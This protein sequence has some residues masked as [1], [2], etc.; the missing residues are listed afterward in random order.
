[1]P[2]SITNSKTLTLKYD[3]NV[4]DLEFAALNYFNP[5]KVKY[6]YTMGGFDKGWINADNQ[7]RKATYTNLDPG[8]YVFKVRATSNENW[9]DSTLTLN[10]NIL[11]PFWKTAWAYLLYAL[12]IVGSLLYLRRRG[13]EKLK[14]QFSIEKEREEAHRMHELDLMKIKFFTNVSHEFRTPLSLIMAPVDKIL[15]QIAEPDIQR[16][17]LLVNRI[18]RFLFLCLRNMHSQDHHRA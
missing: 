3:D 14:A 6:Q 18:G 10:I 1:M 9:N 4:F 17:L 16:Q 15:R 13:I 5:G 11:P 12:L 7:I 2:Q 8:S